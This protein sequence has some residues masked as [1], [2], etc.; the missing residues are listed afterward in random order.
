MTHEYADQEETSDSQASS[1]IG[2]EP[3]IEAPSPKNN[4]GLVPEL[5]LIKILKTR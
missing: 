1:Y 4:N 2:I 3:T 5:N